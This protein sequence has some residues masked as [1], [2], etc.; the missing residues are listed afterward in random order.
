[1]DE[2]FNEASRQEGAREVAAARP[3]LLHNASRMRGF[4]LPDEKPERMFVDR[5][6]FSLPQLGREHETSLSRQRPNG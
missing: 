4:Q 1:M 2:G 6:H 3:F 5:G